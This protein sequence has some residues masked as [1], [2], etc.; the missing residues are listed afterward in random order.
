MIYK[1]DVKPLLKSMEHIKIDKDMSISDIAKKAGKSGQTVS[2]FFKGRQPNLTLDT[3]MTYCN[4]LDCDLVIDI[5][6]RS[7]PE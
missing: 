5:V 4:A 2:N 3:L 1:G 7:K 6:R